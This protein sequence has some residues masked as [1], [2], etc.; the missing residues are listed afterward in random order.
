M[1]ELKFYTAIHKVEKGDETKLATFYLLNTTVNQNR[2]CVT[3]KSLDEAILTI[4]GKPLGC[5]HEY[6]IDKHYKDPIKVGEFITANKPNGYALGTAKISDQYVWEKLSTGEWGPVSVVIKSFR[7]TC[8]CCGDDL[9]KSKVPFQHECIQKG[10]AYLLIESFV[11]DR[12]DFVDLP[13]Y[14]Q[15]GY[16]SMASQRY[17]IPLELLA[18]FY[19]KTEDLEEESV[20]I[21]EQGEGNPERIKDPNL[22]ERKNIMET[23]KLQEQVTQLEQLLSDEKIARENLEEQLTRL[24]SERHKEIL[25]ATVESRI[26]AGLIANQKEEIEKLSCFSDEFL[27]QLKSDADKIIQTQKQYK[28]SPKAKNINICHDNI[29]SAKEAA[30]ERLFGGGRNPI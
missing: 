13:A 1:K 3:E 25:E 16:I 20:T 19:E 28:A 17:Q 7:E 10:G 6:R 9:T 21:L 22:D 27:R 29:E 26:L 11:F 8:S 18:S 24:Q 15:A 23:E 5:G 4:L 2:W 12:V 14:P 30:R